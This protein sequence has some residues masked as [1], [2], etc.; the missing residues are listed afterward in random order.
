MTS[1][2]TRGVLND[3]R[4]IYF[5]DMTLAGETVW[6]NLAVSRPP[7]YGTSKIISLHANID[8]HNF[9]KVAGSIHRKYV[10]KAIGLRN[11]VGGQLLNG[12]FIADEKKQTGS[13]NY[14]R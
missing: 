10:G 4:S 8:T 5:G 14:G 1:S 6:R 9:D 11:D 2:G 7:S 12:P 3:T 13:N